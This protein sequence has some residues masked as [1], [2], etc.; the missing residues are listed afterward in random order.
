MTW[1]YRLVVCSALF[2]TA[3]AVGGCHTDEMAFRTADLRRIN[4]MLA[5]KDFNGL[6]ALA[7][8]LRTNHAKT[9]LG[10]NRLDE[11]YVDV[12]DYYK[13]MGRPDCDA[14]VMYAAQWLAADYGKPAAV[15]QNAIALDVSA[16]CIRG[17]DTAGATGGE[18]MAIFND[19]ENEVASFLQTHAQVGAVDPQWFVEMESIATTQSWSSDQFMDLVNRG[20]QVDPHYYR[21]YYVGMMYFSPP[22]GGSDAAVERYAQVISARTN[23]ISRSDMYARLYSFEAD[24]LHLKNIRSETDVDWNTMRPSMEH[25]AENYP[26]P[27]NWID[28]AAISCRAGDTDEMTA[29]LRRINPATQ[30]APVV[31]DCDRAL[32][33]SVERA[34]V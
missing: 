34:P 28:L 4:A 20:A 19:R 29:L 33:A 21:I 13:D 11:F 18:R 23:G 2:A 15:I 8:D 24:E 30:P 32:A 3:L 17:N 31:V 9:P 5:T 26:N 16:W 25:L 6:D 12:Q 27:D 22:W 7:E 1:T 10:K 14:P